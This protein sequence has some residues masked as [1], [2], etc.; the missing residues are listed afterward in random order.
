MRYK[1]EIMLVPN[2]LN[3]P[4]PLLPSRDLIGAV[5]VPPAIIKE[6]AKTGISKRYA[7][8]IKVKGAD[9]YH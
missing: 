7:Q 6:N 2:V 9:L 3:R 1:L 5:L 8:K 4:R